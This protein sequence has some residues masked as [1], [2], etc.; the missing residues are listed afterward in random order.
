M[1]RALEPRDEMTPHVLFG[2]AV[3]R[4]QLGDAQAGKRLG[5]EARLLAEQTGQG[6]LARKIADDLATLR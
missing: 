4:V 2:L 1:E 6:E 3:A 5:E